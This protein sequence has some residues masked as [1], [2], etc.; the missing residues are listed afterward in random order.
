MIPNKCNL[1]TLRYLLCFSL[2]YSR[3]NIFSSSI[4]CHVLWFL[5][6]PC[7]SL[8][9]TQ[10]RPLYSKMQNRMGNLPAT[11]ILCSVFWCEWYFFQNAFPTPRSQLWSPVC[12][13]LAVLC[14]VKLTLN[15]AGSRLPSKSPAPQ[16]Q[17][18]I[19]L[20]HHHAWHSGQCSETSVE[21]NESISLT[22]LIVYNCNLHWLCSRR[23]ETFMVFTAIPAALR[24][25]LVHSRH[26][27]KYVLEDYTSLKQPRKVLGVIDK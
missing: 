23:A 11:S 7:L 24:I 25:G 8:G 2:Q 14:C 22:I 27:K 9:Y 13:T 4:I 6:R 26:L 10:P 1:F 20:F 21:L 18:C 3:L 15:L 12:I 19:F 17:V 5:D 16:Q